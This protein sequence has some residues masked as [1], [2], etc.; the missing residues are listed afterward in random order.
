MRCATAEHV[1]ELLR[2]HVACGEATSALASSNRTWFSSLFKN[3]IIAHQRNCM[4]SC[5]SCYILDFA[6][7]ASDDDDTD[8]SD[9]DSSS[10]DRQRSGPRCLWNY[11]YRSALILAHHPTAPIAT[12]DFVL[13]SNNCRSGSCAQSMRGDMIEIGVVLGRE[14]E[15]AVK[16]VSLSPHPLPVSYVSDIQWCMLI[17]GRFPYP[18][19]FPWGRVLLLPPQIDHRC[20]H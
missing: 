13:K 17:S 7:E 20:K 12:E 16:R 11:L 15:K 5:T 3:G 1:S 4:I 10:D 2:Y 19:L 8:G 6:V 14:V 9:S 18:R